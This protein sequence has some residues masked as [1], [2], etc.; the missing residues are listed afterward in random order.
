MRAA[1]TRAYR[2]GLFRGTEVGGSR[3]GRCRL[4]RFYLRGILCVRGLTGRE[5]DGVWW[6][7]RRPCGGLAWRFLRRGRGGGWSLL[8]RRGIV[9]SLLRRVSFAAIFR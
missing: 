2:R 6:G 1:T 9:R 8:G 3:F 5:G 7:R 4:L